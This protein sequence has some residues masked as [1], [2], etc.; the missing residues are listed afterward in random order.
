[1]ANFLIVKHKSKKQMSLGEL[2]GLELK[3]ILFA[4]VGL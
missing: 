3:H 4:I 1:M 2:R